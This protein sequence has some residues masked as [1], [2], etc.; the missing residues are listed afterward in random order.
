M[1]LTELC[2][3]AWSITEEKGFHSVGKTFGDDVALMHAELSEMLEAH[4]AGNPPCEKIPEITA[5]EE[6]AA[7]LLIRL[8]DFCVVHKLRITNAVRMK[9]DYNKTRPR[10]HGKSY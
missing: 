10:L 4:R 8:A 2:M 5:I 6:E 1:N 9:L 7:D 3:E